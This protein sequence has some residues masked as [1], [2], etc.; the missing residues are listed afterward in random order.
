M[1]LSPSAQMSAHRSTARIITTFA[2]KLL[3]PPPAPVPPLTASAAGPS[4]PATTWLAAAFS[5]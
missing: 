5:L 3:P 4:C 2:S 1:E